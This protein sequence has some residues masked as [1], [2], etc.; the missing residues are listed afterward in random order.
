MATLTLSGGIS[1]SS[2]YE[3][4]GL[5]LRPETFKP[6]SENT[7][8]LCA[9]M[10]VYGNNCAEIFG[11][12]FSVGN[13]QSELTMANSI[14]ITKREFKRK[15]RDGT[16]KTLLRFIVNFKD[17]ETGS[18]AQ[19]FFER[20]KDAEQFK[21]QLITDINNGDYFSAR[22][23]V[24]IANVVELWFSI[25]HGQIKPISIH[26]HESVRPLIIGPLVTNATA[27]QRSH[28]TS[29]GIIPTGSKITYLLRDAKVKD[30]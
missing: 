14:N 15:L 11:V 6:Y 10:R 30:L 26:N 22:E 25:R 29:K 8:A 28:F 7:L 5:S 18:R 2:K 19:K 16:Q 4:M 24:T 12:F 1:A 27:K 20:R 17:P 13:N 21:Q 3:R 9:Y 23:D